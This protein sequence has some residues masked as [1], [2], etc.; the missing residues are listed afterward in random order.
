MS[1][2]GVGQAHVQQKCF[3]R[4]DLPCTITPPERHRLRKQR[5]F[6]S[7]FPS[8]YS[9]A[10]ILTVKGHPG[11]LPPRP[12]A[13]GTKTGPI[14]SASQE[15]LRET[16]FELFRDN[17]LLLATSCPTH[18]WL[19]TCRSVGPTGLTCPSVGPHTMRQRQAFLSPLP[20][21]PPPPKKASSCTSPASSSCPRADARGKKGPQSSGKETTRR[22]GRTPTTIPARRL[23]QRMRPTRPS[24]RRARGAVRARSAGAGGFPPPTPPL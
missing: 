12:A 1:F 13:F 16:R 11:Q 24:G 15:S 22:D 10:K 18:A 2:P 17:P 9:K 4:E 21:R 14:W 19:S 5:A 7:S 8:K 3:Q 6:S 23:P 20:N